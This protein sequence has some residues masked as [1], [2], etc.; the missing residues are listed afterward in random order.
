MNNYNEYKEI[1][2]IALKAVADGLIK[3]IGGNISLK[4]D[5]NLYLITA[6]GA[7]LDELDESDI[8]Y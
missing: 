1:F 3:T 7:A 4:I 8:C 2:K 5:D 6:T